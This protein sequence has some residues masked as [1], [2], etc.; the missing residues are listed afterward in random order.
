LAEGP[1]DSRKR[2][3]FLV[4]A[5]KH[6]RFALALD[7]R[8]ASIALRSRFDL[9]TGLR[10]AKPPLLDG[11]S[12]ES[13][14]RAACVLAEQAAGQG[15]QA[16]FVRYLADAR[17]AQKSPYPPELL[18]EFEAGFDVEPDGCA[19]APVTRMHAA[20][21]LAPACN[22]ETIKPASGARSTPEPRTA[23]GK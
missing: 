7:S 9:R 11:M 2:D 13:R 5:Q 3:S 4:R 1:D 16:A 22:P 23:P 19:L 18:V 20:I 15:D 10:T 14:A 17:A 8:A 6:L 12:G 21:Y